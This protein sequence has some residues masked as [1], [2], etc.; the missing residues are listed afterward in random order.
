MALRHYDQLR[1]RC[2]SHPISSGDYVVYEHGLRI[3]P[4]ARLVPGRT[5]EPGL[6]E[7]KPAY[8]NLTLLPNLQQVTT[9]RGRWKDAPHFS[10]Y[11]NGLRVEMGNPFDQWMVAID[12]WSELRQVDADW[13]FIRVHH[14][15]KSDGDLVEP[16]DHEGAK[17]HPGGLMRYEAVGDTWTLDKHA[18]IRFVDYQQDSFDVIAEQGRIYGPCHLVGELPGVLEGDEESG[19]PVPDRPLYLCTIGEQEYLCKHTSQAGTMTKGTSEE[20]QLYDKDEQASGIFKSAKAL[21]HDI[22]RGKWCIMKRLNRAWLVS[23]VECD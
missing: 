15:D 5:P 9:T 6:G 13:V 8:Q 4:L 21:F 10:V 12:Y 23:Q 1:L 7:M 18:F 16:I 19:D 20:L 11:E 14:S 3:V 22:K 17:V 2:G